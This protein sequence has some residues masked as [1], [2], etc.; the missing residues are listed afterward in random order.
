LTYLQNIN[1]TTNVLGGDTRLIK[2]DADKRL[3]NSDIYCI[4]TSLT[5]AVTGMLYIMTKAPCG[6]KSLSVQVG[7][8][9]FIFLNGLNDNK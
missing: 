5:K 1:S 8:L 9:D 6:M 4:P 3:S 2:S 7:G